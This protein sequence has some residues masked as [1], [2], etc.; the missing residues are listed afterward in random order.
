MCYSC[1]CVDGT[2][3]WGSAGCDLSPPARVNSDVVLKQ[4]EPQQMQMHVLRVEGKERSSHRGD[5]T[6][7]D[8]FTAAL[9][10]NT[11]CRGPGAGGTGGQSV[12]EFII[13]TFIKR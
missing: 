12:N 10:V 11:C 2:L 13:L 7:G 5:G 4:L 1:E 6:A 9:K 3:R 8:A